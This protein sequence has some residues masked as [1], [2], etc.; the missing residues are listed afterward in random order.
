MLEMVPRG[1]IRQ[2]HRLTST[3]ESVCQPQ[4]PFH[5][6]SPR[7]AKLQPQMTLLGPKPD[8]FQATVSPQ[9]LAK[10]LIVN[11]LQSHPGLTPP[12]QHHHF[13]SVCFDRRPNEACGTGDRRGED[14]AMREGPQQHEG[15]HF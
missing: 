14:V 9:D 7:T 8:F 4:I 15:R 11:S 10:L 6:I 5:P 1:P 3:A 13:Q 12:P 2:S